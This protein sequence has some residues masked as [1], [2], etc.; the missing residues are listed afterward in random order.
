MCHMNVPLYKVQFCFTNFVMEFLDHSCLIWTQMQQIHWNKC[1]CFRGEFFLWS[2]PKDFLGY[3]ANILPVLS[4]FTSIVTC[5]PRV[6]LAPI[7][8]SLS[9]NL[10]MYLKNL[11]IFGTCKPE[12]FLWIYEHIVFIEFYTPNNA[13]S[14]QLYISLKC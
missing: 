1:W 14:I 3:L 2:R 4:S 9:L 12:I 10:S 13:L 8:K 11:F 7:V 6:L 5:P